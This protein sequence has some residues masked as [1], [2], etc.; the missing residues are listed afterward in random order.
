MRNASGHRGE[1]ERQREKKM[2][3]GT[4]TTLVLHK[5]CKRGSFT[6]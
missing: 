1:N 6:L 5:T 4:N 3:T 2:L